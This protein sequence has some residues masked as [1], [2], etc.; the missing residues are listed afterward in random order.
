MSPDTHRRAVL[1]LAGALV[2][3]HVTLAALGV[4]RAWAWPAMTLS[5]V[6][7]VMIC[8][9]IGRVVPAR[10]RGGYE[11]ALALGFPLLVLGLWQMGGHFGLINR[12]WFPPPSEIAK[13][14]WDVSV[15]YNRFSET[16]L[17]GRPWL[18]PQTFAEGGLAAVGTLLG[19]SHLLATVGRVLAGFV[20]G[21]VPGILVGVVMGVNQT[22]RL[23]LDTTLSAI[24]VLP[25]IA[26][27]PIVMLMFG[28]PFGEGPKI[29]VVALAVFILMA[30]NTM[31]GVRQIDPVYLMAARN[32]GAG[33][34]QM[35]RHVILPGALP[36][37]FAGLRIALGTAMI[38][39]ISVE[40]LRA[41]QGVGY[42]TFYYWEVL[43]PEKMYA[44]LVVVMAMG[45]TFT[46]LLSW[47]QRRLMPWQR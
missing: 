12:L 40:F 33:P 39:I 16:S 14:L 45:V 23:M 18:I 21:A 9:R 26:I 17:L 20:L 41:K 46:A 42:M 7:L 10:A 36:V 38:V 11:R 15:T 22:V 35:L 43:V 24:Y 19:E 3:L 29:V 4:W 30:I 47:L 8:E 6:L 31:A 37:I 44:G 28:D 13:A 5:F 34:W 32:Y 2:A 1:M 25:K 27:F